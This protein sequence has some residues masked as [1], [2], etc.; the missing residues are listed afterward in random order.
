MGLGYIALCSAAC[1][2]KRVESSVG[3]GE[4]GVANRF[5]QSG[6]LS[7]DR[8]ALYLAHCVLGKK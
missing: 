1:A 8:R 5:Q 2:S 3:S 7:I 6:S 4:L